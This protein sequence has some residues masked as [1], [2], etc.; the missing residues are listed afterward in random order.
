MSSLMAFVG[1]A[2]TMQ[3]LRKEQMRGRANVV[4][5]G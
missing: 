1:L 5:S 2:N 4:R 3:Q